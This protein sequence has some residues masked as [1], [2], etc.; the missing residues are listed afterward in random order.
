VARPKKFDQAATL[1]KALG[2]FWR[3]GYAGT[4]MAEL[5]ETMGINA[6]SLYDTYGDKKHLFMAALKCYQQS[7]REWL[8]GLLASEQPARATIRQLLESMVEESLTDP[9]R[10]GCFMLNTTTELANQD[11]EVFRL[12]AQNERSM[13]E[14]L[15]E[16]ISKGKQ[17]GEFAPDQ[18][19]VLVATYLFTLIQGLRL[20]AATNPDRQ[21]L[22]ATLEM[23]LSTL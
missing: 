22:K 20:V 16:L 15:A 8:E 5:V 17:A 7:Q 9:D 10:K 21:L 14:L 13:R 18:D 11:E 23:A 6:P 12:V 4:S 3:K 19:P 1:Q 2:V